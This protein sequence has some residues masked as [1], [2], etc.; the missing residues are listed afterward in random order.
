MIDSLF[1]ALAAGLSLW[2]SREKTKY[3]DRL[4]TI[5]REY[6]YEI[7]KDSGSRSDA[8]LDQLRF[9]LLL[10][11]DSFAATAATTGAKN[12]PIK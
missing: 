2:E 6:Y 11:T 4:E 12:S 3:I 8:R 7:N 1:K 9:E 5:R 10:V